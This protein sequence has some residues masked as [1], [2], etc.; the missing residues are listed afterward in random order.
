MT[1]R[2]SS[3]SGASGLRTI[4]VGDSVE[5]KLGDKVV[6]HRQRRRSGQ[7]PRSPAG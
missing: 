6:A 1:W 4:P 3:C 2:C 5:V 7:T